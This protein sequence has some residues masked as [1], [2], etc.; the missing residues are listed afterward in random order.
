MKQT[1][2]ILLMAASVVAASAQTPAPPTT[3]G[4]KPAVTAAKPGAAAAKLPLGVPA[5]GIPAVKTIKKTLLTVALHYQEIKIGAGAVAEP[6][7]MYKVFYTGYREADGVKFDSTDDHPRPPLKDKDGKPVL[8][9]DGK[10]KL[11][12]PQP[13]AFPQGTGH[14]IPG[15]DQGF[16]G[17][18]VGGKRRLF[19]PWQLGY[20]TRNIP[21]HGP[22]HPGLPAKSDL[23]FDVEL[24]DVTDMPAMPAPQNHPPMGVMPGGQ[25]MPP[26]PGTPGAPPAPA[27]PG[28]PTPAAAPPAPGAAPNA[29]A[30]TAPAAPAAPNAR[31]EEHTSEL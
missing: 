12:V 10:P 24:V 29:A 30:P 14:T 26:R 2:L 18:N 3:A 1:V 6:N 23:I 16:A 28:A 15:F 5:P 13:M 31:S 20:G 11:D 19:I 22:G 4:A 17:M 7:K 9:D 25:A 27:Q 21:D 8:G